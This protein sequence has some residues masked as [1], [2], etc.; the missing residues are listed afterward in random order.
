MSYLYGFGSHISWVEVENERRTFKIRRLLF[1]LLLHAPDDTYSEKD[2]KS[3]SALG[4]LYS[5]RLI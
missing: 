3:E 1:F 2:V 4:V 5:G